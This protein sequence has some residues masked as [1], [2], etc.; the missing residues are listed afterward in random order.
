MGRQIL[1]PSKKTAT[2]PLR[3]LHNRLHNCVNML[4]KA[5]QERVLTPGT[6]N[7]SL[8]FLSALDTQARTIGELV[9]SK[10][11]LECIDFYPL[12]LATKHRHGADIS[13]LIE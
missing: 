2:H 12:L 11:N 7:D 5:K 10:A 9:N 4:L 3:S 8:F 6:S 1:I 13:L